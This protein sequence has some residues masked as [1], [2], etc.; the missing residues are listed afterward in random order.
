M[1][2][3]FW[4]ALCGTPL[5]AHDNDAGADIECTR[6]HAVVS[7]PDNPLPPVSDTVEDS[8]SSTPIPSERTR[9]MARRAILLLFASLIIFLV[10]GILGLGVGVY[11]FVTLQVVA[12]GDWYLPTDRMAQ[13]VA[14]CAIILVCMRTLLRVQAY[15]RFRPLMNALGIR[16]VLTEAI[17]GACLYGLGVCLFESLVFFLP[18]SQI[19]SPQ[20][21]LLWF[22]TLIAGGTGTLYELQA[23]RFYRELYEEYLDDNALAHLK[24]YRQMVMQT[25]AVSMVVL[26]LNTFLLL[27]QCIFPPIMSLPVPGGPAVSAI[28]GLIGL[29][30]CTMWIGTLTYMYARVL[31]LCQKAI[32]ASEMPE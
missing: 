24:Q 31:L 28:F 14:A 27:V 6:C 22:A 23:H 32:T 29:T 18:I 19:A 17:V 15:L 12:P 10:Q 7:V 9:R 2:I 30:A 26:G 16:R 21:M 8:S 3:H 1:A 20:D 25:F 13:W 11:R 5:Q 4:C